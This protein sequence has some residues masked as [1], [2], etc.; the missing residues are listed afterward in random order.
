MQPLPLKLISVK[1]P[2]MQWGL[3]FIGEINS[4]SL[5]QNRWILSTI[6]YFMIWIEA[7]PTKQSTDATIIQ[8]LEMNILLIFGCPIKIITDNAIAF[9]SKK[10]DNFC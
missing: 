5:V 7:I 4:P 10:M 3:D 2:F 9:K 8:F 6:D 1:V